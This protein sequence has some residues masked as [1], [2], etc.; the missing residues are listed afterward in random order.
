MAIRIYYMAG[1]TASDPSR[2]YVDA[3]T[4]AEL[5]IP[6]HHRLQSLLRVVAGH[7]GQRQAG[8]L[9]REAAHHLIQEFQAVRQPLRR[10]RGVV[11]A[12][13]HAVQLLLHTLHGEF[14]SLQVAAHPLELLHPDRAGKVAQF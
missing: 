7:P 11:H 13:T 5:L 9:T 2:R 10:G 4:G 8:L 14:K 3:D 1:N 12:R 6:L